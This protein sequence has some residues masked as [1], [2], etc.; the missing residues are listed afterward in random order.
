MH[1]RHLAGD[2][3]NNVYAGRIACEDEGERSFERI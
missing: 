3:H 1:L 2:C